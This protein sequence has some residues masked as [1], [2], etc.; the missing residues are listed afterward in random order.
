M[1]S[2]SKRERPTPSERPKPPE[3]LPHVPTEK[4]LD[5][6]RRDQKRQSRPKPGGAKRRPVSPGG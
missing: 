3:P 5:A 4:S 1:P 2:E 6:A